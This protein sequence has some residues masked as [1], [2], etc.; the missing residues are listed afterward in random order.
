MISETLEIIERNILGAKLHHF[1]GLEKRA[2][3]N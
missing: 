3:K 1:L 2:K